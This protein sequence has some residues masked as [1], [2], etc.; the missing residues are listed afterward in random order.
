MAQ[1]SVAKK[2]VKTKGRRASIPT[3]DEI[4]FGTSKN[5]DS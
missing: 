3:W 1:K 4:L 5:E 2:P